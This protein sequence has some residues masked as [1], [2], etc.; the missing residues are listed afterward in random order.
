MKRNSFVVILGLVTIIIILAACSGN[1]AQPEDPLAGTSWRLLFYRKSTVLEGTETTITFENGQIN[2]SAG[3]NSYFGSYEVSG[4][5][6]TTGQIGA[7]EMYCTEP[8]G[9]W[10][11]EV[12]FLETLNDA[13]RYELMD[14]RLMIF[15]SDGEALTFEPKE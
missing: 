4:Q 13:Q 5:N 15:R 6:L 8:E 3:C 12:F 11:Q 9:L 14:E 1:D 10:E 7:T 2:G